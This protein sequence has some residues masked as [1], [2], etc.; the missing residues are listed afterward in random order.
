MKTLVR[1]IMNPKPTTVRSDTPL[2]EA[3]QTL[4]SKGYNGLPVVDAE[5]RVAGILTEYDLIIEES[6][7]HLPTA[8]K[9]L[10]ELDL[11]KKDSA[12]VSDD[13]KKIL[14]T[15]VSDV[16]NPDPMT[17]SPET[18]LDDVAKIFGEHHRVN[19]LLVTDSDKKLIGILARHDLIKLMGGY[20][21]DHAD[22]RGARA[23]DTDVT[24]YLE[25][26][27]NKFVVVSRFRTQ[28][29]LLFSGMFFL[30]G[31]LVAFAMIVRI[32]V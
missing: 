28:T 18:T 21:L 4:V 2:L 12:L 11:Y 29:W 31:F 25:N 15:K 13:L 8:I 6:N 19:P 23:A 9:V 1:E 24:S 16:M 32:N 27:E 7:I 26:I 17:V 30:I 10:A 14:G 5:N 3:T 20:S 22:K